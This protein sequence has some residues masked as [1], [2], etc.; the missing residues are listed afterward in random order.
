[1]AA[2][3][4]KMDLSKIPANERP[5]RKRKPGGGRWTDEKRNKKISIED[6]MWV[7]SL[8]KFYC[9][10]CKETF[11]DEQMWKALAK[12]IG[13][14]FKITRLLN[15]SYG[16]VR[17]IVGRYKL[18]LLITGTDESNTYEV[19][20]LKCGFHTAAEMFYY[21][22]VTRQYNYN[23]IAQLIGMPDNINDVIDACKAFLNP[24]KKEK[25]RPDFPFKKIG[26]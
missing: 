17:Q 10:H 5:G 12:D 24:N 1:M 7:Y 3:K 15:R 20:A 19:L 26:K 21:Y 25:Y 9:P 6:R 16:I 18:K 4:G 13:N 23:K 22:R 11:T 14:I 8:T 2:K